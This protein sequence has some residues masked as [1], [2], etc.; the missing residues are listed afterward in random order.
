VRKIIIGGAAAVLAASTAIAGGAFAGGNGAARSGLSPNTGS[1]NSECEAG[2]GAATNGFAIF[3]APGRPGATIKFNGE[4]SLKR[5]A[6]NTTYDVYLVPDGG[7]CEVPA[8]MITTNGVGNGNA[9]LAK[10]GEGA[11]TYYIV[12]TDL[13]G[14]EQ[15]ATGTVTIS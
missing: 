3:N 13:T 15:F 6:P 9:H 7:D 14:N 12:L 10:P 4:V 8:G 2:S 11:G 1:D 5:G